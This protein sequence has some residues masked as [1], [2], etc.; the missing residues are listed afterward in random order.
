MSDWDGHGY[1]WTADHRRIH[2]CGGEDCVTVPLPK[3][4]A[5]RVD[6]AAVILGD[7][8]EINERLAEW[9]RELLDKQTRIDPA[10]VKVGDVVEVSH[11]GP[12]SWRLE[13]TVIDRPTTPSGLTLPP[14]DLWISFKPG[15]ELLM[16]RDATVR[17]V[18]RAEPDPEQYRRMHEVW[19]EAEAAVTDPEDGG[20]HHSDMIRE[21]VRRG[22]TV[23]KDT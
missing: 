23:R 20:W 13:G 11:D 12:P 19:A 15:G 9:E 14:Y 1:D 22:V 2:G 4:D 16:P 10:D 17:L 5:D 3:N 8:Y 7:R 21:L 6:L 18:R